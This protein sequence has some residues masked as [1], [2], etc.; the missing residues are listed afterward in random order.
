M[1]VDGPRRHSALTDRREP[2]IRPRRV[3][4]REA[5]SAE[6]REEL[7]EM[8]HAE[9]AVLLA[10]LLGLE[11]RLEVGEVL[12][13]RPHLL[14]LED[15]QGLVEIPHVLER[16]ALRGTAIGLLRVEAVTLPVAA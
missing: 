10:D 4:V 6:R 14:L 5:V 11:A 7:A 12:R 1:R 15:I 8:L 13:E 9:L 2:T 16:H 3:E